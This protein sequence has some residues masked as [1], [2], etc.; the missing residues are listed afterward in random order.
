[1]HAR[2][3]MRLSD[4]CNRL[5]TTCTQHGPSDSRVRLASSQNLPCGSLAGPPLREGFGDPSRGRFCDRRRP[6]FGPY[7]PRASPQVE[8]RLTATLQLP[9]SSTTI[10][11]V[12]GPRPRAGAEAGTARSWWSRDR[13][14]LRAVRPNTAFSAASRA[15]DVASDALCRG[16]ATRPASPVAERRT[17]LAHRTARS[18]VA[19]VSSKTAV[20][21]G[22][23]R[24]PSPRFPSARPAARLRD[25]RPSLHGETCPSERH[26][27]RP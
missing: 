21:D 14:L 17:S 24:L 22:P 26:R 9:P 19:V 18:A 7:G 10:L 6:A 23:G 3:K 13:R 15:R 5:T 12:P 27:C 20:F 11:G 25:H 16:P 2:G 4:F 8:H 1:M